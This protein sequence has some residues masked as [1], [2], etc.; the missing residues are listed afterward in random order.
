MK[1]GFLAFAIVMA[2]ACGGDDDGGG[3]GSHADA[4]PLADGGDG[5]GSVTPDGGSD[6]VAPLIWAWG[7]FAT[8]NRTQLA[9]FA[10][11]AALPVTPLAV[12]PG[13]DTAEMW[14]QTGTAD[15]GPF[16]ISPDS[17]RVAFSAD[18][19]MADRF[20]LYV[21]S[22]DGGEP[23]HVVAGGAVTAGVEKV[24][25]SP[26]GTKIAFVAD[27]EVDGQLDAYVIAADAVEGTP[28]KVSPAHANPSPD[29]D[30]SQLAWSTDSTK[31]V[32]TGDFSQNDYQEM[33]I[34]D[35]TAAE[36]TPA[37]VVD[38]DR[39]MS[40]GVGGK[41]AIFPLLV[42][43]DR[44]L[45]KSRLD[46]DDLFK[47]TLID[48]DGQNEAPLPNSTITRT[49]D[50]TADIGAA[51]LSGDRSQIAFSADETE[52]SFDVWVMPADGSMSPTKLTGG[53]AAA[54]TA[55]PPSQP[56][57]WSADGQ[58][59]AFLADY[60][61]DGRYEPYVVSVSGGG[62]IHLAT[63]GDS[64]A[65]NK[66]ADSICWTPSGDALFMVADLEIGNDSDLFRLDPAAADQTPALAIGAPPDGDLGGVRSSH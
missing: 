51:T 14:W 41:G 49:D 63:V 39:I 3:G 31:I 25:F 26:D 29:L 58:K 46:A 50:S 56:L 9:A 36:P 23:T 34:A 16:D 28:I 24:R 64:P 6:N 32:V 33:W 43:G 22:V 4:R 52:T 65:D 45:F 54:D 18:I 7:D 60:R 13:G 27:L 8:D 38:R 47:L 20:D 1:Q 5:D 57:K 62:Q 59:I 11:D 61:D 53:L 40:T 15:Y 19:D 10:P 12:F 55:P 44:I 30:A 2:A 66:D 17:T 37:P 42:V 21:A 35:A 48:A